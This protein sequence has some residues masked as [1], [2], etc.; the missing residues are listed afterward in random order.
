MD[1]ARLLE[2]F[3]GQ[4]VVVLGDLAVDCYVDTRPARVSREVRSGL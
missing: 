4:K 3:P 1:L 2:R